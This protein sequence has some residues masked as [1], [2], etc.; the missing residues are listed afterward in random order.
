M[1]ARYNQ[2]IL[3]VDLGTSGCKCALVGLDGVVRKWAVRSFPLHVV[4][5]AGAEQ[6]PEDWWSAFVAAARELTATLPD[7]N[8][9]QLIKS[10]RSKYPGRTLALYTASAPSPALSD[11]MEAMHISKLIPKPCEPQEL[12]E[13]VEGALRLR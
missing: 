8:G 9:A 5:K 4:D 6:D 13:A 11:F 3:A 10:L 7:M 12:L 1:A 2:F